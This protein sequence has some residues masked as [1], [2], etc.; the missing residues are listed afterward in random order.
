MKSSRDKVKSSR[1]K[2]KPSCDKHFRD[3]TGEIILSQEKLSRNKQNRHV[4]G[5][6]VP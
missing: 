4:T 3:V 2:M 6:T 5:K 1:G